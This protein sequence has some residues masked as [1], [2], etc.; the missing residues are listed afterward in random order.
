MIMRKQDIEFIKRHEG[1]RLVAYRCPAGVLTI[2]YGH[3]G[4][5]VREGLRITQNQADA[6]LEKDLE[7]FEKCV[8]DATKGV[9]L[10]ENQYAALVSFCY[11]VGSKNFN[12]ST[13]LKRVKAN[14]DDPDIVN[15]FRRWNKSGTSVLAG[16]VRR[17]EEEAKLYF[18]K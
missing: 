5:D 15:Q 9:E 2:G 11:N 4:S 10:N 6:L 1:C 14:A 3:T 12:N 18:S 13:L 17:R 7:K 16:L 8:K